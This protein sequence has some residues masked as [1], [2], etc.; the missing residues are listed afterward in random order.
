[1]YSG[2]HIY[3]LRIIKNLSQQEVASC[4]GISQQALSKWEN[5]KWLDN[6][7]IDQL[8]A[9]IHSSRKELDSIKNISPKIE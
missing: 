8:L 4:L 2:R 7:K 3:L 5:E 1:M 6:E 9:A